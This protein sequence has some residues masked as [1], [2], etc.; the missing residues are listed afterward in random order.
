[1]KSQTRGLRNKTWAHKVA[2]RAHTTVEILNDEYSAPISTL[3]KYSISKDLVTFLVDLKRVEAIR[4]ELLK[5]EKVRDPNPKPISQ[6]WP[7]HRVSHAGPP[8]ITWP[9]LAFRDAALE[10]LI[11]EGQQIITR[12]NGSLSRF[13]TYPELYCYRLT[14]IRIK[15]V[16]AST[17]ERILGKSIE[18]IL[19]YLQTG[20]LGRLRTCNEPACKRWFFAVTKHQRYCAKTCR[21]RQVARSQ[22]FKERRARYMREKYRPQIKQL[23]E[24]AKQLASKRRG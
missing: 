23:E 20:V 1:M 18:D 15:R 14:A 5:S 17:E 3:F 16:W 7:E 13:R 6:G 11:S 2:E 12:L 10:A 22:L 8:G 24:R 9:K 19:E 4:R 21:I